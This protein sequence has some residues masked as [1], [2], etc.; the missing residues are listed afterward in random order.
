M[1][2]SCFKTV[3]FPM[4]HTHKKT[5]CEPRRDA[6]NVRFTPR[7]S[8]YHSFL[9]LRFP[10]ETAAVIQS[11]KARDFTQADQEVRKLIALLCDKIITS[12]SE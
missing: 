6:A 12:E 5:G 4:Q 1:W 7:A 2:Q 11:I 8:I 9:I 3:K 10:Q